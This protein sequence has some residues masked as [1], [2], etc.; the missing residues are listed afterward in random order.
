MRSDYPGN[1]YFNGP[2]A[3]VIYPEAVRG[4]TYEK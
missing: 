4:D 1:L 2:T 3:K